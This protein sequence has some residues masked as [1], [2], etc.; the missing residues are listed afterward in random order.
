MSKNYK[1]L[2]GDA[3]LIRLF[4]ILLLVLYHSFCVFCGAWEV[5]NGFP[6][7]PVYWWVGKAASSFMLETFVF[8]SGYLY[9]EQIQK[10]GIGVVNFESTILRKA[11]R[12]CI[13]LFPIRGCVLRNVL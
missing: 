13:A 6:E 12:L 3:V 7:I 4:L 5:P 2:L 1:K 11:K 9:G 8:L 10:K